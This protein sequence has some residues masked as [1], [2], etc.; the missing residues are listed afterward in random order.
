MTRSLL[1]CSAGRL[2]LFE[3]INVLAN[4][5]RIDWRG[6]PEGPAE[7]PAPL[8]EI[9]AARVAV[10]PCPAAGRSTP[11]IGNDGEISTRPHRNHAEQLGGRRPPTTPD[12]R[13]D[14]ALPASGRPD[15]YGIV[16]RLR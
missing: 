1:R 16:C 9:D 13:P 12:A 8:G 15:R 14:R 11:R 7:R 4:R 10:Q 5:S 6:D 3:L 2:L